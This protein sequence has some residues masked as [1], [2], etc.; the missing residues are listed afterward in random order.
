M[1]MPIEPGD[2]H[3]YIYIFEM[4]G[5]NPVIQNGIF[6]RDLKRIFEHYGLKTTGCVGNN[7]RPTTVP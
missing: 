5:T 6:S 2:H 3:V 7:F 1:L 4:C